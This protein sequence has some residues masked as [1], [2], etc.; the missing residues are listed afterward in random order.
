[1]CEGQIQWVGHSV[2]ILDEQEGF[3]AFSYSHSHLDRVIKYIDQQEEHHRR[4]SFREE[5][6]GLL[7]KFQVECDQRFVFEWIEENNDG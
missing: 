3:G 7:E 1:M 5:Y 2:R 4:K 6:L